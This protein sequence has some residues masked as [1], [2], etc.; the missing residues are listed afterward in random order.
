MADKLTIKIG[1]E[2]QPL[3][4][5]KLK[6]SNSKLYLTNLKFYGEKINFGIISKIIRFSV[7]APRA[8]KR[9]LKETELRPRGSFYFGLVI[10][11]FRYNNIYCFLLFALKIYTKNKYW[12]Y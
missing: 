6:E 9:R 8:R 10:T 7:I 12:H 11:F 5:V 2:N 4:I 3:R 1:I